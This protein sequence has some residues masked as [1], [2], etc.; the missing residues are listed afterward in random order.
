MYD[1]N[2]IKKL[3]RIEAAASDAMRGFDV[4]GAAARYS[5]RPVHQL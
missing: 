3:A 5:R 1:M 4:F 2:N